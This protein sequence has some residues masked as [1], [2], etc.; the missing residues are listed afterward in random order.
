MQ[1][2]EKPSLKEDFLDQYKEMFKEELGTFRRPK[3]KIY[4]EQNA[5]PQFFKAGRVP[6]AYKTLVEKELDRV[7][8][9]GILTPVPFSNWNK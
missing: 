3:V 2:D 4:I 9:D 7:I 6:F 8:Q 5:E 1:T